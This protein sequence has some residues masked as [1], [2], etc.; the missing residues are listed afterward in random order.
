MAGYICARR[1]R[2][3]AGELVF[4]IGGH[5]LTIADEDVLPEVVADMPFELSE[6][7]SIGPRHGGE[8]PDM[9]H[10]YMNHSCE[11]NAGFASQV[12]MVAMRDIEAGEECCWDYA[13][14]MQPNEN[15]ATYF[16]MKCLCGASH[17]RGEI[18]EDDW[19]RPELQSR[20]GGYFQPYLSKRIKLR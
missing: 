20:Y 9:P 3:A 18:T 11:P 1:C 13:M 17:C 15:S 10:L 4:V 8:V 7:F 5:I 16:R 14:S 6:N 12:C 2:I 19:K